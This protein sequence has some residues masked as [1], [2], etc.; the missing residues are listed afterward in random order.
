MLK[1]VN[2][3]DKKKEFEEVLRKGYMYQSPV[4]GVKV[5]QDKQG[6]KFGFVISKKISKRAVDRNRIKRLIA[7]AIRRNLSKFEEGI[8]MIFLVK[9]EILEWIRSPQ[10]RKKIESEILRIIK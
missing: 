6:K 3:I 10:K 5:W 8:R 1:K 7:E 4:F 2:R 9:K